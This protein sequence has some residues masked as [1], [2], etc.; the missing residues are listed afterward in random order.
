MKYRHITELDLARKNVLVRLD[1]N[2]PLKDGQITDDSRIQQALPTLKYLLEQKC[3]IVAMSHLGRPNGQKDAKFSLE[4]VATRLAEL[5]DIEVLLAQDYNVEPADQ[6]LAQI[7]DKQMILLENLRFFP[8]EKANDRDFAARLAKGMHF[9]VNDAFGTLHRNHA[10]IVKTCEL[11]P[12]ESRAIGF[13]VEREIRALS[14]VLGDVKH[15]Y[16][17]ILGGSKVSDKIGL[18]LNLVKKCNDILIGGAMAYPFLKFQGRKVG[19]S[20]VEEGQNEL[21]AAVYRDAERSGV[22][23]HLPED[24]VCAQSVTPNPS[25]I[26]TIDEVN[27]PDDLMGLDIGPKTSRRYREIIAKS[28]TIVWN[29]PMGMFEVPG[30]EKGTIEVAKG[31]AESTGYSVAGGGDTVAAINMAGISDQ[32]SFVSTGGGASLTFLEGSALPGLKL[33]ESN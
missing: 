21:I 13:L 33:C 29:G 16:A 22:T 27:I 11:I 32:V 8:G 9:Y 28:Q 12:Q 1:L 23:I 10:S 19:K 7:G 14:G 6:M 4:P 31:V 25:D 17:V 26:R 30:F 5:L 18:T 15:P 3:H 24:H 20:L 2:V